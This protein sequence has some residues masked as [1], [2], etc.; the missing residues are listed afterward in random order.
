MWRGYGF[1]NGDAYFSIPKGDVRSYAE[2]VYDSATGLVK[3]RNVAWFT[4]I[5]HGRRHQPLAL[6]SLADNLRYSKHREIREYGY[7]SYDNL[8]NAIDVP[9]IDAIPCDYDGIMGVPAT[10]LDKFNP[11]QFEIIGI[12]TGDW[13]KEVGVGKNYRG[14]TDIAVTYP[15]GTQKCPFGRIL[16]K[17][18]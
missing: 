14:R 4:N 5:D 7:L 10:I 12:G 13:G 11:E 16:I 9:F 1:A 6:M 2:G 18:R 17:R 8:E 15:D 3:F